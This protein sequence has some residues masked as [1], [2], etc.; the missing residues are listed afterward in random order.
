VNRREERQR[1]LAICLTSAVG[2]AI[3]WAI[4]H[5]VYVDLT[6]SAKAVGYVDSTTTIGIGLGYV[7][8]VGGTLVLA[9]IAL[10][11]GVKYLRLLRDR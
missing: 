10:W 7:T 3:V 1:A 2:A 4:F 5:A 11:A 8:M 6:A 9:A